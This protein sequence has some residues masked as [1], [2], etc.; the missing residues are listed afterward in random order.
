VPDLVQQYYR[1]TTQAEAQQLQR[2]QLCWGPAVYLM[3]PQL[4]TLELVHYNPQDERLNQYKVLWNPPGNVIFN[5]TPVHEL[6][7]ASDEEFL[8]LKA[9][10][11]LLL[12]ISQ[13]AGDWPL[14]GARLRESGYVCL[15]LYSFHDDDPPDLRI[16]VKA[17]EYPWWVCLPENAIP[18][19]KEG[20]IRLDRMQVVEK[21]LLE[22]RTVALTDDALFLVSEWL[23]YYLTGEIDPLFLEYRSE[24]LSQIQ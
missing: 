10:R 12:V 23:R 18:R 14:G 5:H 9:K 1:T 16:R 21:R 13:G 6:H 2:G 3:P 20:F 24:L 15:P 4:A 17:H 8:V 11:R 7:L 19:L 22:P